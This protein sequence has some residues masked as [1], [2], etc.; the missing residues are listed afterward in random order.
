L[1]L[2]RFQEKPEFDTVTLE[3]IQADLLTRARAGEVLDAGSQAWLNRHL[4]ASALKQAVGVDVLPTLS[5]GFDGVLVSDAGQPFLIVADPSLGF[6]AQSIRATDIMWDR[7]WQLEKANFGCDPLFRFIP[8]DRL[9]SREEDP[10]VLHPMIQSEVPMIR[11]DLDR[12]SA[13]ESRALVMHGYEVA[14]SVCAKRLTESPSAARTL[15]PWNPFAPASAAPPAVASG[16][17]E[18]T[19]ARALRRSAHRRVWSTLLD[20][21]DWPTYVFVPLLVFVFGVLPFLGWRF[22]QRAHLHATIVNAVAQGMP[23]FRKAMQLIEGDPLRGWKPAPIEQVAA[24]KEVDHKDWELLNET[25]IADFRGFYPGGWLNKT[26]PYYYVSSILHVRRSPAAGG[27]GRLTLVYAFRGTGLE[28]RVPS[29]EFQPVVKQLKGP[30]DVHGEPGTLTHIE[31]NLSQV[32]YGDSVNLECE[33]LF[34]DISHVKGYWVR[35]K[36]MMPTKMSNVWLLF[37]SDHPYRSYKLRS[38][39][40]GRSG[41]PESEEPRYLID[42][43]A[44]LVIAWSLTDPRVER[45]YECQWT[46][47]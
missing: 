14:R 37:P 19:E 1:K 10:T 7:I 35:Y 2:H 18:T 44:G 43:P 46:T 9:V 47:D 27:D 11:T 17:R 39:V 4:L 16:P 26:P 12:F 42:H 25:R 33:F 8:I 6:S 32:P 30:V 28:V 3:Q 45:T 15:P 22:Y 34:R 21:R 38:F 24:L 29:Q 31:L 23:E 20:W 41:E 36:P 5:P 13:L 40:A